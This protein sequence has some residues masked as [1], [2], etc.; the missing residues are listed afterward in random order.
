MEHIFSI[1]GVVIVSQTSPTVANQY[2]VY[3]GSSTQSLVFD[4]T[5]S[6][7]ADATYSVGGSGT[8]G[9]WSV[10]VYFSS[11]SDGQGS[12]TGQQTI[13]TLSADQQST[14]WAPPGDTTIS[15]ISTSTIDVGSGILCS[16]LQY[17]CASINRGT[18]P[19][20]YFELEGDPDESVLLGCTDI[21][22]R[23][24]DIHCF[25]RLCRSKVMII[26]SGIF[27]TIIQ[28]IHDI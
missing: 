11:S 13:S 7:S 16:D 12:I 15:S 6:P 19:S 20:P 8:S 4:L 10:D 24:M 5:F 21:V 26:V 25:N 22:C 9:L 28:N 27:H 1:S 3:E 17:F 18:N 2:Q 14:L 23:G